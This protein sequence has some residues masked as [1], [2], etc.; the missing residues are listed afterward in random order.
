MRGQNLRKKM[1]FSDC[2]ES[3][4]LSNSYFAKTNNKNGL[5]AAGG[6]DIDP[7]EHTAWYGKCGAKAPYKNAMTVRSSGSMSCPP[8]DI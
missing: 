7:G 5:K 3:G 8:A 4:I 1:P 2:L 6:Q